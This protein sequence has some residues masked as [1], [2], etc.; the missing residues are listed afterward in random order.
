MRLTCI[1]FYCNMVGLFID[2][3]SMLIAV[4]SHE[5]VAVTW[6]ELLSNLRQLAVISTEKKVAYCLSCMKLSCKNL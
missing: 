1:L 2:V 3:F 5:S 4:K 6:G